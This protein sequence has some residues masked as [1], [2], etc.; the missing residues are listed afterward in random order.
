MIK[1]ID[2]MLDFKLSFSIPVDDFVSSIF[3]GRESIPTYLYLKDEEA[4]IDLYLKNAFEE[5]DIPLIESLTPVYLDGLTAVS[6]RLIASGF[7]DIYKEFI[8][9]PSVVPGEFFLKE[10]RAYLSFRFHKSDKESVFSILRNSI[11]KLKGIKIDYLGPSNGITWELSS[12]NSRIPLMVVQYSFGNSRGF[13]AAQGESSP[14]IECRLVPKKYNKYGHIMYGERNIINDSDYSICAKPK[15]FAT[16]S[17]SPQ[18]EY[19]I[20][21]LERDRIALGV[22]FENYKKGKINVTVALPQLLLNPFITRLQTVFS[23]S[24]NQSPSVSLIAP[25]SEDLFVDL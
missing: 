4:W 17:I 9:L 22:L 13:K 25:Y 6:E 15:I 1:E 18:T 14:I 8:S 23:E 5:K 2:R 3:G 20:G 10:K 21:L 12:I 11:A 19:L 24:E 16:N 7:L